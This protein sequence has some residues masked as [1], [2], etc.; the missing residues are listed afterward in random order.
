MAVFKI[1]Y[2]EPYRML[3]GATYEQIAGTINPYQN[4]ARYGHYVQLVLSP[5][6]EQWLRYALDLIHRS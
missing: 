4:D 3:K 1:A 5:Q 6:G 2:P